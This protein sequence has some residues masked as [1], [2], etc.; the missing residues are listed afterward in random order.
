MTIL[1]LWLISDYTICLPGTLSTDVEIVNGS[2]GSIS[3]EYYAVCTE[4]TPCMDQEKKGRWSVFNLYTSTGNITTIDISTHTAD[5]DT[6]LTLADAWYTA[7]IYTI[8]VNG[9]ELGR[10]HGAL[11][12][13]GDEKY[14]TKHL[15]NDKLYAKTLEMGITH[16]AYWGTFRVPK[17]L[18]RPITPS[19]LGQDFD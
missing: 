6:L 4:Y 7:E 14:S 2:P 1:Y 15:M 10:T 12:L 3:Y 9:K 8:T 19:L 5:G 16:G 17:G 11:T 13:P 18:L